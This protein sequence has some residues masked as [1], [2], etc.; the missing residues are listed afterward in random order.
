MAGSALVLGGG[1]VTG[2]A[3]ELGMLYGLAEAGV[4]LTTADLLVGTSAG[5]VVAAQLGSGTSL[6]QLYEGQLA[7]VGSEQAAKLNVGLILRWALA[8]LTI[9][10]PQKARA[11]V[12]AMALKAKTISEADRRAIIESRLPLE[13]WPDRPV[14][15]AVV[16]ADD[17]E[18]VLL[19]AASGVSL[20]DA[21]G[22]SCAVP[23]V[24]PPVTINGRR[25]VDGGVRS[26]VNVDAA[27]GYDPVVVI[28]PLTRAIG[29]GLS[30]AAQLAALPA[31]TRSILVS[32]DAAALK[33]IGRNV[34]DPAH[35]AAAAQ[36][37]RRQAGQVAA[38][39]ARVWKS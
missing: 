2:V 29:R 18:Y 17:G 13:R 15:I 8:G 19:D 7:G 34:L 14:R 26:P 33:A 4:D 23:G 3:W 5:S 10:D 20:V 35:R 32:P 1:G 9:R 11:R 28:A 21:V 36:A 37:G 6:A 31:G 22:A 25:Y 16:A 12:G 38:D 30:P 27:A 24:W 39:V